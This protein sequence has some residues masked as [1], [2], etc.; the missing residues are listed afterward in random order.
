MT[1]EDIEY[2]RDLFRR[3]FDTFE[4]AQFLQVKEHVVYNAL[5]KRFKRRK[6]A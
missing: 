1:E 3:G 5:S 2:A 4:I 6:A